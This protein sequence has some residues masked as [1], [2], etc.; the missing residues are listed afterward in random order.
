MFTSLYG[1]MVEFTNFQK[2]NDKICF[3]DT[4]KCYQH[5]IVRYFKLKHLIQ[6]F[7]LIQNAHIYEQK[8]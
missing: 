6:H 5:H 7:K 3:M 2:E 1:I 4:T 8:I